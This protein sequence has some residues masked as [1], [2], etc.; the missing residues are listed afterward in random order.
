LNHESSHVDILAS[1]RESK[2]LASIITPTVAGHHGTRVLNTDCRFFTDDIGYGVLVAKWVA[3]RLNVET[4]F[5]DEIITWAQR[6]RGEEFL[7]EHGKI[8]TKYCLQEKY[9]SGIP[10]SY[11]ITSVEDIL[12]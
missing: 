12:D 5:I 7:D 4:P 10:E 2:Q 1:V 3:E 8:N 11:G 9:T 6:L